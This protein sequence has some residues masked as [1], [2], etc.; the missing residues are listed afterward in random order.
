MLTAGSLCCRQRYCYEHSLRRS[1]NSAVRWPLFWTT[2]LPF[3]LPIFP[4]TLKAPK[5]HLLPFYVPTSLQLI[6]QVMIHS[7]LLLIIL[8][9]KND[10][11]QPEKV[12]RLNDRFIRSLG[13]NSLA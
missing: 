12:F 10:K 8:L 3:V 4:L 9:S 6:A 1:C 13:A 11:T 2:N 5:T 7:P